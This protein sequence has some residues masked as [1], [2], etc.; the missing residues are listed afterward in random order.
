M[1]NVQFILLIAALTSMFALLFFAFSG[2]SAEKA[3]ARRLALVRGRHSQSANALVEAQ[4]RRAISNMPNTSG[5]LTSL[6][7]NRTEEHT[8][9]LQ[10]LMRI[11][12]A[13]FCLKKKNTAD[14]PSLQR[15][16][17]QPASRHAHEK[18]GNDHPLGQ[19]PRG[20]SNASP[21]HLTSKPPY[22]TNPIDT[23]P[24][25]YDPTPQTTN[26]NNIS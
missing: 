15:L 12:Y 25:N 10:S 24:Q 4:M 19:P 20:C 21:P 2:P 14:K 11:S 18:R 1:T 16:P 22:T 17:N 3:Q 7:P 8:S 26:A 5:V 6:I 13:V 23:R 9:E